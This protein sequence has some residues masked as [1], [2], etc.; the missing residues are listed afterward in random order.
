MLWSACR[1]PESIGAMPCASRVDLPSQ[2][3]TT[4]GLPS[5]QSNTQA[6]PL[7][8]CRLLRTEMIGERAANM[9]HELCCSCVFVRISDGE[10]ARSPPLPSPHNIVNHCFYCHHSRNHRHII[11]YNS[12]PYRHLTTTLVHPP[13]T[14]AIA[15]IVNAESHCPR[16]TTQNRASRNEPHLCLKLP[17]NP[18]KT[19]GNIASTLYQSWIRKLLRGVGVPKHG[20]L[21]LN[22]T[23]ANDGHLANQCC[24]A[25]LKA[26]L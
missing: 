4:I 9:R 3:T 2:T 24:T 26:T 10:M 5:R 16:L 13:P 23:N 19:C 21:E 14:I 8:C 15:A 20:R 1:Q 6:W 11:F 12:S 22:G 18:N 25:K 17:E 7:A